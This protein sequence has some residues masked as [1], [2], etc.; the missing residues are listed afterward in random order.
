MKPIKTLA[1]VSAAFFSTTGIAHTG[2]NLTVAEGARNAVLSGFSHP[3]TGVDHVLTLMLMGGTIA[4]MYAGN[5][6]L[7]KRWL[8]GAALLCVL[9]SWS[10]LHYSGE[11][12][13]AHAAGFALTSSMLMATG[14]GIARIGKRVRGALSRSQ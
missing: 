12:F 3:F 9:L 14:A 6:R 8:A 7:V 1:A 2:V 10:F 11:Y 4:L 5:G 13:A